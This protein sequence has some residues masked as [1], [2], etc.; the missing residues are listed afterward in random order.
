M[1]G[2]TRL[3]SVH[4]M[5]RR[6]VNTPGL[7]LSVTST[8]MVFPPFCSSKFHILFLSGCFFI[9]FSGRAFNIMCSK[10][11]FACFQVNSLKCL[12]SEYPHFFSKTVPQQFFHTTLP[13]APTFFLPC[14]GSGTVFFFFPCGRSFPGQPPVCPPLFFGRR[15]LPWRET[16]S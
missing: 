13:G 7:P 3:F 15:P 11:S 12:G 1:F 8:L 16:G 6:P 9:L 14:Q 10:L 5:R 4:P 2:A